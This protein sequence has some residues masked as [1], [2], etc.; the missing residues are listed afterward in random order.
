[1]AQPAEFRARDLV[2][3]GC[4][5]REV[6]A[7]RQARHC[8]LLEAHGRYKKAMDHVVRPKDNFHFAVHGDVH[9]SRNEIVSGCWIGCI[10]TE[11]RLSSS[12]GILQFRLWCGKL[13][14]GAGIAEV[15]GK[16]HARDFHL[17]SSWLSRTKTLGRPD[18]TAHQV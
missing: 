17:H 9:S 11:S 15:P 4:G 2:V 16:L 13:A 18:G 3:S 7:D 1:M 6:H 10:E 5:G 12:R 14:I 8:V